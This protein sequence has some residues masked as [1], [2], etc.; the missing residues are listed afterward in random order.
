[1]VLVELQLVSLLV[2]GWGL[3]EHVDCVARVVLDA[4]GV[5]ILVV[6]PASNFHVHIP[7]HLKLNWELVSKLLVVLSHSVIHLLCRVEDVVCRVVVVVHHHLFAQNEVLLSRVG[8]H[9][10]R[11]FDLVGLI[12]VG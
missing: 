10:C 2:D 3:V 4:F 1:M 12:H 8:L 6:R 7:Y 9:G 11:Q 5:P